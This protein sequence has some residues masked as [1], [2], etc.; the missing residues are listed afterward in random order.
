MSNY[1][2]RVRGPNDVKS[3]F[4]S[5]I[6]AVDD[7]AEDADEPP[8]H[9][10]AYRLVSS[11]VIG[12]GG[13]KKSSK[14]SALLATYGAL[15]VAVIVS[16]NWYHVEDT[17]TIWEK[18]VT[19][20]REEFGGDRINDVFYISIDNRNFSSVLDFAD[21]KNSMDPLSALATFKA[22][23]TNINLRDEYHLRHCNCDK[24]AGTLVY[25]DAYIPLQNDVITGMIIEDAIDVVTTVILR[26]RC[27]MTLGPCCFK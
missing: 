2:V 15:H 27:L 11:N 5:G 16:N 22:K 12:G 1:P 23:Y 24:V 13:T 4:Y 14:G 10:F 7:S 6:Y 8:I 20:T 19:T 26:E 9:G 21:I 3:A 25:G 17:G 18:F